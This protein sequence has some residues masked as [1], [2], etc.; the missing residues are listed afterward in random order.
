VSQ[1]LNA[2]ERAV[3]FVLMAQSRPMTNAELRSCAG[4]SLEG[5]AR[6]RLNERGLVESLREGRSFVHDLTDDGWAWCS[7]ELSAG[8][9]PGGGSV[10]G[11]LHAVLNGLGRYLERRDLRLSDVFHPDPE[12]RIRQA[13]HEAIP[14]PGRWI[15]LA[16]LRQRVPDLSREEIDRA[17]VRMLG[18]QGI[19]L[20]PESNRKSLTEDDR[21]GAL[22]VGGE[23]IHLLAIHPV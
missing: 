15:G 10:Q 6:R 7:T 20:A 4:V 18:T 12:T 11:A 1:T 5:S 23:D 22:R 13:Y 21:A 2:P 8:P 19:S 14:V 17:L 16:T 3:M 9:R